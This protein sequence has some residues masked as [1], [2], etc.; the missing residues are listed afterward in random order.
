MEV[1]SQHI[2]MYIYICVCVCVC[3][4]IYI[5]LHIHTHTGVCC[6]RYVP[7]CNAVCC[8]MHL[9]GYTFWWPNKYRSKI[10]VSPKIIVK[11]KNTAILR[12]GK[13][14][15]P[16]YSRLGGPKGPSGRVRNI[17]PPPGFDPRTVQPV[18][19]RYTDWAIP[20]NILYAR[21]CLY[22]AALL[23]LLLGL[24]LHLTSP[25][26]EFNTR[27]Q[28]HDWRSTPIS[29]PWQARPTH[30]PYP[31]IAPSASRGPLLRLIEARRDK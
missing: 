11:W 22:Y 30:N 25:T 28:Q 17:S 2:Y 9:T 21:L 1:A 6:S 13:S 5:Y 18:A 29:L 4:C 14:R 26:T 8:S 24:K 23:H 7:G 12:P 15:Y 16:L 19:S 3:V 10:H 27:T 20:A 31:G